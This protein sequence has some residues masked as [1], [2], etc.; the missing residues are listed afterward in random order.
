[1]HDLSG[2]LLCAFPSAVRS[3]LPTDRNEPER[4]RPVLIPSIVSKK[5]HLKAC[6]GGKNALR[7]LIADDGNKGKLG[8]LFLRESAS[9]RS[10]NIS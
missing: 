3:R 5:T 9:F 6:R 1:M 2:A 10:E 4:H 8:A 7:Y